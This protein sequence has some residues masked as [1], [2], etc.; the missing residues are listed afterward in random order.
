MPA[1]ATGAPPPA[2]PPVPTM[3]TRKPLELHADPAANYAPSVVCFDSITPVAPR[4]LGGLVR[5][6]FCNGRLSASV[7][8]HGGLLEVGYWAEQHGGAGQFFKADAQSAWVKLFRV[9]VRIGEQRYHLTLND[10]SLYPFGYRSHCTIAGVS[11]THELLL[12]PD[13]LVLRARVKRNRRRLPVQFDMVH[14][15]SCTAVAA[16]NR[17]WGDFAFQ[18]KHNALIVSCRDENP[19]PFSAESCLA[20]SGLRLKQPESP[21]ATTWIGVTCDAPLQLRQGLHPRHKHYLDSRPIAGSDAAYI[22]AFAPDQPRLLA[23]LAELRQDVHAPCDRLVSDYEERLRSRPRID[24]GD[25]LLNSAFGQYPEIIEAMKIGDRPGAVRGDASHYFVWSWDGMTPMIPACLANDAAYVAEM[26]RFFQASIDPDYGIPLRFTSTFQLAMKEPLP[27]QCQ[28]IASLYHYVAT[29]GDLALANEM[30]PACTFLL[31][32]CR[33]DEVKNT[34]LVAGNALWPD[35]PEAMGEDGHDISSLNNSLV[36]QAVRAMEHLAGALGR[37]AL[38]ADCRA[39]AQRLRASFVRYLY[40]EEQGYFISSCSSLTLE[41]RR[42]YCCQAIFW[43]T[44]FARELAAHAP[45]RI[46]AFMDAHLRTD[47]CLLS[48]PHWDTAW[49]ADGNQLGSSYPTADYFY[50]NVHKLVGDA[51]CLGPWL[52]DVG[53]FWQRHTAPE[54]FTP[55][56]DNEADLG[57]DNPGGKQLQAVTCWYASLYLGMCGMDV[58][59]EG[60]TLTPWGDRTIDIK[61]LRLR[62]VSIDLHISGKGGHVAALS[63]NGKRLPAGSHK[64]AWSDLAGSTARLELRRT[65]T[66]PAHPVIVRADGLRIGE[67]SHGAGRLAARIS[68][69][70]SGEVVIRTTAKAKVRVDGV[71]VACVYE[72]SSRTII[73]PFPATTSDMQ[74]EIRQ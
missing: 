40:D 28:Y 1:A 60:L 38:A 42:H 15:E 73:I 20:Q 71:A 45:G 37:S 56:A 21:L 53:W 65:T 33:K 19:I 5:D 43:I 58:D 10:T 59:H 32:R 50:L 12:L 11:F 34:G 41:P 30:M 66:A 51:S 16:G 29:T 70:M 54:A 52:D 17:T 69:D 3:T 57:P 39:W 35:F 72:A 26:L 8:A 9:C 63:L 31:D 74:L 13:A 62:G 24:V 47:K 2:N 23:R 44:P 49:M 7:G 22:V 18:P 68:G 67:L 25:P 14:M 61:G 46:A 4:W 6:R 55:E 27:A 64:V 36:Y 48:L